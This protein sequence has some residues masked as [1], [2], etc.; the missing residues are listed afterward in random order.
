MLHI[1]LFVHLYEGTPRSDVS[2]EELVRFLGEQLG[3]PIVQLREDLVSYWLKNRQASEPR[4]QGMVRRLAQA[5]VRS[6]D[7]PVQDR[8]PLP[9]ELDFERRFLT[10]GGGKPAGLLYDGNRLVRVYAELIARDEWGLQHCHVYLTNQLLGTWDENDCRH[11]ARVS[12]YSFPS[13]VSTSGLVEG[14]ARPREFYLARALGVPGRSL[15]RGSD[16]QYLEHG[17][18]QLQEAIKGYLLQAVFYHVTGDPF[19]E[20]RECR[21]FNAHWQKDLIHAQLREGAGLCAAHR[22]MLESWLQE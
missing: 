2:G 18:P 5:R 16:T 3:A 15:D 8:E 9:G 7:H 13:V 17:D 1:P 22:K 12:I 11:H 21:L 14:P 10:A 19:C 6:V 4:E 20:D